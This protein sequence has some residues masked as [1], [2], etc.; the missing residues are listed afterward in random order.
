MCAYI[1]YVFRNAYRVRNIYT[2]SILT[3]LLYTQKQ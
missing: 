2:G 3:E 1:E